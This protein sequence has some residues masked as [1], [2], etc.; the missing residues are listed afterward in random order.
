MASRSKSVIFF[1]EYR[2]LTIVSYP[3]EEYN[4]T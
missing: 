2:T 4:L 1:N 3:S